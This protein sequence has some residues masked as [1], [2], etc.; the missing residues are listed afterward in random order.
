M[1]VT[2]AGLRLRNLLWSMLLAGTV[3]LACALY[4]TALLNSQEAALAVQRHHAVLRVAQL[5]EA[6]S[7]QLDATLRSVDTAL[8]YLRKVYVRDRGSFDQAAQDVLAAYPKDMLQFITVFGA[9]GYLA[10]ASNGSKERL[11]F[12][13]REHFRVHAESEADTLYVSR[14]II[15]RIAKAPLIQITRPIRDGKRFL[16]VIGIPLRPEYLS[17]NLRSL[18][19]DPSDTLA[20]VRL[21]GSFIA[22][23][24]NLEEALKTR[25]PADRPL[26]GAPAGAR[27][28]Y[29][30]LST[31]EQVP[32]LFSWQRLAAWPLTTI[33]AI[34]EDVEMQEIVRRQANQRRNALLAMAL[35]LVFS[36]AVATLLMRFSRKNHDLSRS[37]ARLTALLQTAIDGI[38]ILDDDGKLIE[39]SPSFAAMLGYTPEEMQG[40]KVQDWDA[41]VA[42]QQLPVLIR[43]LMHHQ[44]QFETRHRR[45]DGSC[46]DVEINAK[47]IEI[48]GQYY[49]YASA[50]NVTE[51]LKTEADLRASEEKLRDLYELSPLGIALTDM[52]G[53]YLEFNPAFQAI[54]GY[55]ADELK[56]LDYWTLTPRQYEADEARQIES[57]ERNGRYGP[58]EKE[59]LRQDGSRIPLLLNGVLVHGRDGQRYI[60]SIVED[61]S[62]RKKSEAELRQ[63]RQHLEALVE[64]RTAALLEAKEAAEAAN[65]AK[66][67]FLANMSHEIRTPLNAITGMA[68][69]LKR[70]GVSPQ[71]ADRLDKIDAAGIHLLEIINAVL[72]LTKI[73]ADKFALDDAEVELGAISANVVSILAERAQ[74]KGLR[75]QVETMAQPWLLLGDPTR[76]QQALLNYAAN[77]LKFTEHG[78]IT[79]RTRLDKEADDALWIR[80]E[81]ADSG[82][83]IAPEALPKL[84]SAFEQADNSIT[85][86]YGGTGLGLAI[87]K[88][89]AHLRGGEVGVDSTPGVGSTFWFTARLR[90][91]RRRR[92]TAAPQPQ[93]ES[94]EAALAAAYRG[95]QILL[96][97]DEPIN[98]E[99]TLCLLEDV[100]LTVDI[101]EDGVRAV[102]LAGERDYALI[103]M[104]MQMPNMDGLEATRRI[105]QLPGHDNTPIIAITAN[106]FAEDRARCMSAGM[107]DFIAKPVDPEALFDTLLHWLAH[108]S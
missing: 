100:G 69:L 21:D 94:A 91:G 29:R 55:P 2:T 27:G 7:Q 31:V 90:K 26:V 96:A 34:D 65:V 78:S 95:R 41:M 50:R 81:V 61:I 80:F 54:C 23:S 48:E 106:A 77:A 105:R 1:P 37:Q 49:L 66:S 88:K 98:R 15:G 107:D 32:R 87:S 67:A 4:W 9:D 11:Y 104:D 64:E 108:S 92:T 45:K 39:F 14:P 42:D 79:L 101:A 59:Y 46:I 44:R 8:R 28:Q 20:I 74:A 36:L 70:S 5:D 17:D 99:V 71:Q 19:I 13:D 68:H 82:I 47:G 63:H 58:Y 53:H 76:L 102:S 24:H 83:G 85:R 10:Y 6:A 73:E 3:V 18:R 62:E 93:A 16:G 60:W 56:R 84:F 75:L 57:L 38:H 103:L 97:E 52:Q 72:D 12:G 40:L 89:L 30:N 51:R 86:K 25:L 35:I 33:A 22:R 43:E